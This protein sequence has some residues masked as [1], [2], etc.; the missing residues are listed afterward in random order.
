MHEIAKIEA[1]RLRKTI[2]K[3]WRLRLKGKSLN[4]P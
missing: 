1:H 2:E 3:G 4:R